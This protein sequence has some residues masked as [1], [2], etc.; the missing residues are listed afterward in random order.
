[1]NTSALRRK[2]VIL[3]AIA[4]A[5]VLAVGGTVWAASADDVSGT[6]RDRV[7]AAATRA[8][9]GGEAVEV[10]TS[11]DRGEAYE[12]EVRLGDG[13]EVDVA[14][15]DDLRVVSQDRDDDRD[16][17]GDDRDD[18]GDDHVTD[19]AQRSAA[20]KAARDA[21]GGGTVLKVEKS[22]DRSE[23]FEVE[24]RAT[25]GTVWDVDLAA[26]YSVLGKKVD[27]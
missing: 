6:D 22:D 8:A 2:R 10:E 20:G 16:D 23:A 19:A 12:V 4:T 7:A 27:D 5:A 14:L 13:T 18:D 9:G 17:D 26:D 11:D 15:D 21:V 25:D 24:V 1:M 3:P